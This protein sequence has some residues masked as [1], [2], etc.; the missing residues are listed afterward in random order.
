MTAAVRNKPESLYSLDMLRLASR[1]AQWPL[2]ADWPRQASLR[3]RTCGSLVEISLEVDGDGAVHAAGIRA[4]S[5]AVG[6]A[7]AALMMDRLGGQSADDLRSALARL[8]AWLQGADAGEPWPG[9]A[10]LAPAIAY[11]ARHE[12]ILLPFRTALAALSGGAG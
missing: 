10:I 11:P 3:S 9:F 1:L 2:R 6:Q 4:Q 5:C 8:E 12:A 7:S